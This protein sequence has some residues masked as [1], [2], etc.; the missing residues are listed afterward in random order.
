[1]TKES[2]NNSGLTGNSNLHIDVLLTG[3]EEGNYHMSEKYQR[4]V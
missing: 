1:M 2:A 3:I 4:L